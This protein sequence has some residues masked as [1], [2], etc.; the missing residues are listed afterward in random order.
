MQQPS[1]DPHI[2]T[3]E[4]ADLSELA[5]EIP[6]VIDRARARWEDNPK[7]PAYARPVPVRS[8]NRRGQGSAQATTAEGEGAQ[9]ATL[10]LF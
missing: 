6:A 9:Q 1:S 4:D 3:F 2:E 10:G 8:R 7:H 5:Q